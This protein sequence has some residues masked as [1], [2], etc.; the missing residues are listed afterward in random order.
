MLDEIHRVLEEKQASGRLAELQE[1]AVKRSR[2]SV[3]NPRG[4]AGLERARKARSFYWDPSI[5]VDRDIKDAEGKVVVRAGTTVNPLSQMS[6]SKD[7]LFFDASDPAQVK[8]ARAEIAKRDG[9]V[10][11]ILTAGKPFDVMRDWKQK[12]YFDQGGSLVRKLGIVRV[13]SIVKQEGLKLR[14]DEIPVEERKP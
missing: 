13:P 5:R 7:L 9:L 10:K 12:V 2:Q 1:E 3:E 6:L 8:F 4:V 11:P 14:I